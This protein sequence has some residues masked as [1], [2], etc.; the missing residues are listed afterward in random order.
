MTLALSVG[1]LAGGNK[2]DHWGFPKKWKWEYYR[3]NRDKH[4]NE[5]QAKFSSGG[6]VSGNENT[7]NYGGSQPNGGSFGGTTRIKSAFGFGGGLSSGGWFG[8]TNQYWDGGNGTGNQGGY[9]CD[10]SHFHYT[11]FK[12]MEPHYRK[13]RGT[14]HL[15]HFLEAGGLS[16]NSG[17]L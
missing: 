12:M 8:N 7:R 17:T 4:H 10:L 14:I 5:S 11:I 15:N 2:M 9:D 6:G 3:K 1:K 13:F 16:H